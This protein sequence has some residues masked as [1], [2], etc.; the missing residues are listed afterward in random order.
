[1]SWLEHQTREPAA[2][3]ARQYEAA[4]ADL[5][6]ERDEIILQNHLREIGQLRKKSAA[7]PTQ[8]KVRFEIRDLEWV[9]ALLKISKLLGRNL[10]V[11]AAPRGKLEFS[12]KMP[13][14]SREAVTALN[15]ILDPQGLMLVD[16]GRRWTVKR[17]PASKTSK[18]SGEKKAKK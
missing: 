13:V 2:L 3:E 9:P 1:M 15:K 16:D 5:A 7:R 11:A 8:Q 17:K 4:L 12:S 14:S 6:V 10:V 18:T